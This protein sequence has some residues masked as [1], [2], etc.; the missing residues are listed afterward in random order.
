MVYARLIFFCFFFSLSLWSHAQ[1][2]ESISFEGNSKTKESFLLDLI[3]S[4]VGDTLELN[5]IEEDMRALESLQI[6][7]EVSHK[8]EDVSPISTRLTFQLKEVLTIIPVV[9]LGGLTDDHAFLLTLGLNEFNA[10]GKA[11]VLSINYRYFERHSVEVFYQKRKLGNSSFGLSSFLSIKSSIEPL[12]FANDITAFFDFT[13]W[14]VEELLSIRNS[15]HSQFL[16]GG[17]FFREQYILNT[18]KTIPDNI[19]FVPEKV[20][21]DKITLK[22]IFDH[23]KID[24]L[25][26][27]Q[28]GFHFNSGTDFIYNINERDFSDALF[29]KSFAEIRKY[30]RFSSRSNL[31]N[32]LFLGISTNNG[33][34]FTSFVKDDYINVRGVGD[35][36]SRGY[37]EISFNSEWRQTLHWQNSFYLQ[38]IT[39]IDMSTINPSGASFG[40]LFDSDNIDIFGG[41]GIRFG[42]PQVYKTVIRLDWSFGISQASSGNLVFGL[43]QFF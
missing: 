7:S 10:F 26:H 29:F 5:R 19:S 13:Q 8:I 35:R 41:F 23:N 4:R 43:G 20:I 24:Y 32:R 38:A 27:I 18:Q 3:E 39:F 12:Y 34:P 16:I 33:S 30:T 15:W 40:S 11:D 2:I 25:G 14:R 28:D 6:F 1:I 42:L 36:S 17:G 31:A 21:S 37:A 9:N 22:A